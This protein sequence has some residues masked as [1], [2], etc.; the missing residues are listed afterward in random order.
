MRVATWKRQ[1]GRCFRYGRTLSREH[2]DDPACPFHALAARDAAPVLRAHSSGRV[3]HEPQRLPARDT[4]RISECLEELAKTQQDGQLRI[5]PVLISAAGETLTSA[6][7]QHIAETFSCRV[8]NYYGSSEATF[9][10][11]TQRLHVNSDWYIIE[12]VDEHDHPVPPGTSHGVLV[13]NLAN[14]NSA[15][16]PLPDG[17]SSRHD[18]RPLSVWKPIPADP[19]DRAYRRHPALSGN[20]WGDDP[21]PSVSHRHGG[22]GDGRGRQLPTYPARPSE[23]HRALH[24]DEPTREAGGMGQ[25]AKAPWHLSGRTGSLR[26]DHRGGF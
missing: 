10:C 8:T 26:C 17:K 12:P 15:H 6:A 13:T 23:S 19:R 5:H 22:R 25:T 18:H 11:S 20:A 7:R 24:R 1:T 9:E 4:W 16:H 2:H 3:G 14:W 21:Y